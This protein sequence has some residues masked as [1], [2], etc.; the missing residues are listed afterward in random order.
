MTTTVTV[1]THTWPVQVT[2]NGRHSH[3]DD[4]RRSY[5]YS[6]TVEFVPKETK[7]VFSVT[8]TTS[9]TV[10]ELPADATGLDTENEPGSNKAS[11]TLG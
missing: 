5:G 2:T 7:R 8:D 10:S 11:A 1:E 6:E 4:K 3:S 9:V